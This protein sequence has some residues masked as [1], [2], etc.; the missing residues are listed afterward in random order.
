MLERSCL[1]STLVVI[2]PKD[3]D[4]CFADFGQREYSWAV[5]FEMSRPLL[6]ARIVKTNKGEGVRGVN[7]GTDIGPLMP[8]AERTCK[9]QIVCCGQTVMFLTDNVVDLT[10]CISVLLVDQ[11]VFA[12]AFRPFCHEAAQLGGNVA[13]HSSGARVL[14][15]SPFA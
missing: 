5:Q 7:D 9:S 3:S 14:A 15:L 13:T 4:G 12:N 8:I 6:D 11:A 2:E 10:A 1:S